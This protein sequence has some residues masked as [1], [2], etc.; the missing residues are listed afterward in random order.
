VRANIEE[1]RTWLASGAPVAGARPAG[2]SG[3]GLRRPVE[4]PAVPYPGVRHLAPGLAVLS[5]QPIADVHLDRVVQ[6]AAAV[7]DWLGVKCGRRAFPAVLVHIDPAHPLVPQAHLYPDRRAHCV[8]LS[9]PDIKIDHLVHE[10]AHAFSDLRDQWASELVAYQ[11]GFEGAG[12]FSTA[13]AAAL[14]AHRISLRDIIHEG[15]EWSAVLS[16][17]GPGADPGLVYEPSNPYAG[18]H[19]LWLSQRLPALAGEGALRDYL[20][21]VD[22]AETQDD[23]EALFRACFGMTRREFVALAHDSLGS[24]FIAGDAPPDPGEC[25]KSLRTIQSQWWADVFDLVYLRTA[26]AKQMRALAGPVVTSGPGLETL[27]LDYRMYRAQRSQGLCNPAAL[28]NL[29]RRSLPVVRGLQPSTLALSLRYFLL[30]DHALDLYQGRMSRLP[31]LDG[32]LAEAV[33]E[34]V[35]RL[36][37]APTDPLLARLARGHFHLFYPAAMEADAALGLRLLEEVHASEPTWEETYLHLAAYFASVGDRQSL[38][39]LLRDYRTQV[40]AGPGPDLLERMMAGGGSEHRLPA[41]FHQQ[42][43]P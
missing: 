42:E 39:S 2:E 33:S 8:R 11:A 1:V 22:S 16:S 9:H 35:R 31:F 13:H 28:R 26:Y 41:S 4:G 18:F 19:L 37:R 34:T 12:R 15:R 20:G 25:V 43:R 30:T 14:A 5:T 23:R 40:T 38:A 21:Q 3:S 17:Q 24:G 32:A 36:E 27:Y 10:L 6:A 29:L 7:K